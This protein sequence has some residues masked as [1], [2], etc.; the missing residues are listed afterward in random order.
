M[1]PILITGHKGMLGRELLAIA[2]HLNWRS[3]GFDLPE[4]NLTDRRHVENAVCEAEPR[5]IVH[6]AAYTAVDKA[7]RE[8][9]LAMLVNGIGT[10]H[11]CLAAQK[12]DIPILYISTDYIFDGT[13][14]APYDE[15][16]AANPQSV[17]GRTKYAGEW[18][19]RSLCPRHFIV[20]VSWLCG[21]GGANFV[22]TMLKLSAER[23]ELKVV[24]DQHG[25]PTFVRDVAPELLRLTESGMCGTYQITNQGYTTW[26]GFASKIVELAGGR[27]QVLPCSTDEFP[28]PAPRPRNSCLSPKLYELA[29]TNRM[30]TWEAGLERYLGER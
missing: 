18:F 23:E 13:K 26:F 5:L 15:W 9:D 20:R 28:R 14:P 12:L 17:Y 8:P 27:C 22:E 30:P 2:E 29:I 6:C 4:A 7:E 1:K 3:V 25:S 24:N 11:L 19:V 16:D 10:Q 21:H